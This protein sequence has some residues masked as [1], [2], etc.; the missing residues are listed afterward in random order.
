[1]RLFLRLED[2]QKSCVKLADIIKS[3]LLINLLSNAIKFSSADNNVYITIV[4]D[5]ISVG[6]QQ[7]NIQDALLLTVR[8]E[9][10]GISDNDL[11]TIFDKFTQINKEPS[12]GSGTGLGLAICKEIVEGHFGYIQAEKVPSG[13]RYIFCFAS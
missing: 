7:K 1:M 12:I 2:E 10:I 6:K 8:D 13:G 9:G 3:S 11:A 5:N 4:E